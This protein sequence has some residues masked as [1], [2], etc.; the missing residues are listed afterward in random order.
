MILVFLLYA[1][2]A[3]VFTIAKTGLQYTEPFFFVGSRMLLAGIIL[4][5]YDFFSKENSKTY[6][7]YFKNLPLSKLFRLALFNIYLTNVFEFWGLQYLTSCKTCFIYSLSPFL[8]AL[9]SY[10]VFSEKMN[11]RKWIAMGIGVFGMIPFLIPDAEINASNLDLPFTPYAELAVLIAVICSV[12]GWTLLK[13]VIQE[14]KITPFLANGLSMVI[15]G[16]FSLIHSAL[17]ENWSPTPVTEAIPFLECALLL[18]IISNLVCYNLYGFLLKKYSATFISFAGLS[19]PIF[20][21]FFGWIY[22]G[23]M[24]SWSF[25]LSMSILC[26][27]L[28]LFHKE[29]LQKEYDNKIAL[30]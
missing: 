27:G 7:E 9:F 19:T 5:T 12:Y 10:L 6:K 4:L 20:T 14:A 13:Q 1:L 21:A 8:A 16:S 25:F 15:G 17:T 29:E 23:E 28:F 11:Y 3:S 26:I 30:N 2:F 22:L 18:I 24:V